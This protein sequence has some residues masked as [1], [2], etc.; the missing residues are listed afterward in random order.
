MELLVQKTCLEE[1]VEEAD[2]QQTL[3][4]VTEEEEE[5]ECQTELE[6]EYWPALEELGEL[7]APEELGAS[8]VEPGVVAVLVVEGE[9]VR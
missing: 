3:Q 4:E 8:V 7:G 5:E 1:E 9:G 2:H 6:E